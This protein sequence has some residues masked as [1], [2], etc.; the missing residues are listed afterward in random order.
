M[1]SYYWNAGELGEAAADAFALA[2][3]RG[4][5]GAALS[6]HHSAPFVLAGATWRLRL[7]LETAGASRV[8]LHAILVRPHPRAAGPSWANFTLVLRAEHDGAPEF[9]ARYQHVGR[10][11]A[12]GAG[13]GKLDLATLG[14]L[15]GAKRVRAQLGGVC[16]M[17]AV[18]ADPERAP[19]W[20]STPMRGGGS[21]EVAA[22]AVC[23]LATLPAVLDSFVEGEL[24][25]G[26]HPFR[27]RVYAAGSEHRQGASE[28]CVGFSVH[29]QAATPVSVTFRMRVCHAVTDASEVDASEVEL[30]EHRCVEVFE[31]SST[32]WGDSWI[33][34]ASL[35]PA[36]PECLLLRFD[37]HSA[38]LADICPPMPTPSPTAVRPALAA[39][40]QPTAPANAVV[41]ARCAG[42]SGLL[43]ALHDCENPLS[44]GTFELAGSAW[45]VAIRQIDLIGLAAEMES[46]LAVDLVYEGF[47]GVAVSAQVTVTAF[48]TEMF[49]DNQAAQLQRSGLCLRTTVPVRKLR[50][51]LL[52]RS[53]PSPGGIRSAPA[54]D[55]T[56]DELRI[57]ISEVTLS[58]FSAAAPSPRAVGQGFGWT[59]ENWPHLVRIG[60]SREDWYVHS[61]PFHC[62]GRDWSLRLYPQGDG[63]LPGSGGKVAIRVVLEDVEWTWASCIVEL[64]DADGTPLA[65]VGASP[66]Q[67]KYLKMCQFGNTVR[68]L[69][70]VFGGESQGDYECLCV[71]VSEVAVVGMSAKEDALIWTFDGLGS[72]R[73]TGGDDVSF[74]IH[75]AGCKWRVSLFATHP[76][77]AASDIGIRIRCLSR[78][79]AV[80]T[81]CTFVWESAAG[82]EL[83][84]KRLSCHDFSKHP[85]A[86]V[87]PFKRRAVASSDAVQLRLSAMCCSWA[88]VANSLQADM[89][90]VPKAMDS[91]LTLKHMSGFLLQAAQPSG[92]ALLNVTLCAERR[93]MK[94]RWL[95]VVKNAGK[96]VGVGIAVRGA[97]ELQGEE[98]L[99]REVVARI[100]KR[101]D[102]MGD[103]ADVAGD[104][105]E[106]EPETQ[107]R[108]ACF[109]EPLD[110]ELSFRSS[111]L[112]LGFV[113]TLTKLR[114]SGSTVL[115]PGAFDNVCAMIRQAVEC[116]A[117]VADWQVV[118]DL[119]QM[120]MVLRAEDE[121]QV[122]K[123][124]VDLP[125][126]Q[127]NALWDGVYITQCECEKERASHLVTTPEDT[128][129]LNENTHLSVALSTL[130]TMQ[131]LGVGVDLRHV[132]IQC[133]VDSG[134]LSTALASMWFADFVGNREII[135]PATDAGLVPDDDATSPSRRTFSGL[136]DQ[137]HDSC[138]VIECPSV[139]EGGV[140][141]D[142]S[143]WDCS[144]PPAGTGGVAVVHSGD[145][146]ACEWVHAPSHGAGFLRIRN[147]SR[148]VCW[149]YTREVRTETTREQRWRPAIWL[150]GGAKVEV[151]GS[152]VW[153]RPPRPPSRPRA[154]VC[155]AVDG[156]AA[157]LKLTWDHDPRSGDTPVTEY[158]IQ[159]RQRRRV[160]AGWA[161]DWASHGRHVP[162][163]GMES[164]QAE[165]DAVP[166]GTRYSFRI[167]AVSLGGTSPISD[168]C[169][170]FQTPALPQLSDLCVEEARATEIELAWA[171][172]DWH[173]EQNRQ[174]TLRLER[175][176]GDGGTTTPATGGVASWA[177][178]TP[179][180]VA[181]PCADDPDR[182]LSVFSTAQFF[183]V[184]HFSSVTADFIPLAGAEPAGTLREG[185]VV[186]V[187]QT[188]TTADGRVRL[189]L[190]LGWT[191]S[192]DTTGAPLLIRMS[193][194]EVESWKTTIG[195]PTT[196]PP[197]VSTTPVQ[198][199]ARRG[200]V[201][202]GAPR[203]GNSP[204]SV[205]FFTKPDAAPPISDPPAGD[206]GSAGATN[207]ELDDLTQPAL[208]ADAV[209][210]CVT[211]L[212]PGTRY[213][214]T[215]VASVGSGRA[216]ATLEVRT[217]A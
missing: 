124:V 110:A 38:L 169:S 143:V 91:I 129:L 127:D 88:A 182:V 193:A 84:K 196:P 170:L 116:G 207:T 86:E 216:V 22:V 166:D 111:E 13:W 212:R 90:E 187:L 87:G 98:I 23:G 147:H 52:G 49:S 125:C 152:S 160:G 68:D 140:P 197:V 78:D 71:K 44:T 149:E 54:N 155:S 81:S 163:H 171:A 28:S 121:T 198:S 34:R 17:C 59:V 199:P 188:R 215:L 8:G 95:V 12:P 27:L 73:M 39:A 104:E 208:R 32:W 72:L 31:F 94:V 113:R 211:A 179:S 67:R 9:C 122:A 176:H 145:Q 103:F 185:D 177:M 3:S 146:L 195:Q 126:L 41:R 25:L 93:P 165:V 134:L 189:R 102:S 43:A 217:E 156:C 108:R 190:K 40:R 74:T 100:R 66:R 80:V 69:S 50:S 64:T 58:R 186:E 132:L 136:G 14:D 45:T 99:Q 178:A 76:T 200:S 16:T 141:M 30:A 96:G 1:C 101:D 184:V 4:P 194:A 157:S 92:S 168:P 151:K 55:G 109:G 209:A 85:V 192:V 77:E 173:G 153:M 130:A 20:P 24:E 174:L 138:A 65:P 137:V 133:I 117:A 60:T 175:L 6:Q 202:G 56:E 114:R 51:T 154:P 83:A 75:R 53:S 162:S 48:G 204:E 142:P 26:P 159:S 33:P 7:T 164:H 203:L 82:A 47:E 62:R 29:S 201:S 46:S 5:A 148:S 181:T 35:Q 150:D 63:M 10:E 213:K 167:Q 36:L 18:G 119:L 105:V 180:R 115:R 123:A 210:T 161:G 21:R 42:L 107:L 2:T 37:Q 131:D 205:R 128:R 214:V 172:V 70:C 191:D 15:A 112:R 135:S 183:K 89:Q 118:A 206:G 11:F 144:I 158:V 97:V 61:E 139:P 19:A 120:A 79:L 106:T 57:E